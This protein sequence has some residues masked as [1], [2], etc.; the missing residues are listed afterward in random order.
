MVV[1][2]MEKISRSATASRLPPWIPGTWPPSGWTMKANG[3]TTR[4]TRMSAYMNRSQRR[5]LP[6]NK[7]ESLLKV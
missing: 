7:R 3:I 1:P 6:V 2:T 4:L 5:K